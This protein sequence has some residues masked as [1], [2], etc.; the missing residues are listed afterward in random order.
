MI[1]V[2]STLFKGT[3]SSLCWIKRKVRQVA[4]NEVTWSL[5]RPLFVREKVRE[6]KRERMSMR[7]E[8]KEKRAGGIKVHFADEVYKCA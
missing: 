4:L 5:H 2:D 3:A 8:K 7:K 1:C 6:S